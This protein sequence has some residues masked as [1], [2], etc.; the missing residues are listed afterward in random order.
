M[1]KGFLAKNGTVL[2]KKNAQKDLDMAMSS[3]SSQILNKNS[4]NESLK[5]KSLSSLLCIDC[6]CKNNS[7]EVSSSLYCM[8]CETIST[9]QTQNEIKNKK[10]KIVKKEKL[11]RTH[12]SNTV[13]QSKYSS[14]HSMQLIFQSLK[15][16]IMH[17]LDNNMNYFKNH[18]SLQYSFQ[19]NQKSSFNLLIESDTSFFDTLFPGVTH[20]KLKKPNTIVNDTN[21]T[22]KTS[23][24]ETETTENMPPETLTELFYWNLFTCDYDHIIQSSA[25]ILQGVKQRG[26]QSSIPQDMDLQT[27]SILV[28]SIVLEAL[29]REII[30]SVHQLSKKMS[31]LQMQILNNNSSSSSSYNSLATK[32]PYKYVPQQNQPS[33]HHEINDNNDDDD[34]FYGQLQI[35][36]IKNMI[37]RINN[38][39]ANNIHNE[40][41]S[42]HNDFL[43][44]EWSQLIYDDAIRY[45][46]NEYMS[47]MKTWLNSD[48]PTTGTINNTTNLSNTATRPSDKLNSSTNDDEIIKLNLIK[49]MKQQVCQQ[50]SNNNNN[51]KTHN[52]P[53]TDSIPLMAWI[54]IN[55]DT[56]EELSLLEELYPALTEAVKQLH[57]L[58]FIINGTL[59]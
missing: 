57:R 4:V 10:E 53:L 14:N 22:S 15:E 31:I 11:L 23:E 18:S 52:V 25:K 27:E 40:G 38:H 37:L 24:Y 12:F 45:L 41:L 32:F 44:K 9:K 42:V 36:S 49:T 35:D 34:D 33:Q 59:I 5:L 48:T 56:S 50:L 46:E 26:L 29:G 2:L 54:D 8:S 51:N 7:H 16:F 19:N 6:N 1:K 58:P 28:P 43:G 55:K 3:V 39:S 21:N 30:D 20:S 47:E 17:I 13:K